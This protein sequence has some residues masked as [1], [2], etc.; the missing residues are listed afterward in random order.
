MAIIILISHRKPLHA[1]GGLG[2]NFI[3]NVGTVKLAVFTCNSLCAELEKLQDD[4]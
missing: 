3:T 1:V 4:H 2:Y